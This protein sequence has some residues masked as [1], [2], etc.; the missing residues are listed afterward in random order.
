MTD[1]QT[2]S[3]SADAPV[4]VAKDLQQVYKISHGI[5]R[6][7]DRLQAVGGVSFAV[8][9]G[10]TLAVV[11]ESGCGK[12]TLARMV[13]LIEMPTAGELRLDG[14]D[15]VT[16]SAEQRL[17]LRKVV[18][19][20]FQNPYGSLNPRKKIGAILEAPLEINTQLSPGERAEK[21]RNM[22]ALVGLRPE[23]YDRY[24]HMF[25]GGQRQRI[26][27][28]RCLML[29]PALVVADEPVSALDVSIQAQVLNLLADLQ[30]ELGLA[31][32]FISHDLGVVRHIAHDVLVMYL[33]HAVEQGEKKAIFDR[34]LH[35][36]TQALLASTP[37]IVGSG[38]G[39]P[40]KVLTGEL[41]SPLNPPS[42]CVFS[43]RC[44][45]ATN[46]CRAERPVLRDIAGRR[47]A[48]HEAEQFIQSAAPQH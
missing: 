13:S 37:G 14:V 44:T 4:V 26:A 28:A 1:T 45:N 10:K 12:S 32:L 5:F 9:P 42:G 30:Q 17:S 46:R 16:A 6:E 7:P 15:V 20:V 39:S 23:H 18:Q 2:V 24:P 27:I 34:P 38:S 33:G 43:T 31:Y 36:Y 11:G 35:P 22:L 3:L 29:K 47:V 8:Y 19:L 25:S 40:H 41:P 48:C 21:A